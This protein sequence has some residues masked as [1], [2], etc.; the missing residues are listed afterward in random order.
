MTSALAVAIIVKV[1]VDLWCEGGPLVHSLWGRLS[2]EREAADRWDLWLWA[3]SDLAAAKELRRR[4]RSDLERSIKTACSLSRIRPRDPD[5]ALVF[6]YLTRD[7]E[8]A[9]ARLDMVV[10]YYHGGWEALPNMRLKPTGATRHKGTLMLV[11]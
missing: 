10:R 7:A 4:L 3:E 9:L 11:R 1:A 5:V 6:R 2:G 8:A